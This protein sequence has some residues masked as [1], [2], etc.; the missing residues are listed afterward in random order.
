MGTSLEQLIDALSPDRRAALAEMLRPAVEPV[1]IVGIG[2]RFPG[3]ASSL[4][5][6]WSMLYRQVDA[7][8]E[9]PADRW[10]VNRYYDPDVASPGKM[11]T[12]WGGFLSDIGLFAAP[13][14]GIPAGEALRMDPQQRLLLE[15]TWEALESAGEAPDRL[16]GSRTGVFIGIVPDEYGMQQFAAEGASCFNDPYLSLGAASSMAAG[17]LSYLLDFHGPNLS[18]DTAC[19]SS[20]VAVHL[21]C[22]SLANH[23]C[24][25]ALAGGVNAIVLPEVFVQLCKMS[26]LARD[27]RTKAFAASADGFAAGEGCGVVALKRL[28]DALRHGNSIAAVIRGSAV[29]EDGRSASITAPNQEAQ[30]AVIR[31][32]L[33]SARV[34]PDDV[35]YIEAHGSGTSIG[36][37][38]EVAALASVFG[39]RPPDRRIALG[40]VKTNVGHLAAAA[41]IAGLI[42]ATLALKYGAIP[43]NLHFRNPSPKI[44]WASLPFDVPTETRPWVSTTGRRVAGVSAFGWAGTNAH[45]VL[46]EA[47]ASGESGAARSCTLLVLSAKSEAALEAATERLSRH[48]DEHPDESLADAAFT[49]AEGR[50]QFDYRRALIVRDGETESLPS[51]RAESGRRVAFV[52]AGVGEQAAGVGRTWYADEPVFRAAVDRC[53]A[54]L[55]AQLG[56]DLREVMFGADTGPLTDVRLAQPAAFVLDWALAQVWQAWGVMPAMLLGYSLGEYVAATLAGVWSLEDALR[57]VAQ[58]AAWIGD[59]AEPGG[60]VAI[61]GSVDTVRPLLTADTWVAA[62][63]GPHATLVGGR[64]AALTALTARATAAELATQRVS[65][66]AAFHTPVLGEVQAALTEFVAAVPRQAPRIPL[67]SNVTGTWWTAAQAADAAYWAQHLCAPV[68]FAAGV[69]AML[70]DPT[71]VVL[72]VGPGAGLS[73]FIRQHPAYAR[74]RRVVASLPAPWARVS[75]P[76]QRATVLGTLWADGVPVDWDAY[77][78]GETRRRVVLPTYPFERQRYWAGPRALSAPVATAAMLRSVHRSDLA[79]RFYVPTW[80]ETPSI[81]SAAADRGPVLVITGAS[82]LGAAVAQ[83]LARFGAVVSV[84]N[85]DSFAVVNEGHFTVRGA[86]RDNYVSLFRALA[87]AHCLPDRIVH[88]GSVGIPDFEAAQEAGLY[89]LLALAQALGDHALCAP[90]ELTV[91]TAGLYGVTASDS[92][93]PV[94]APVA[95]ACTVIAQEYPGMCCR[96]IDLSSSSSSATDIGEVERL[97]VELQSAMDERAVAY[98]GERRY[99]RRFAPISLPGPENGISPRLRRNGVYLITGGL[100]AVGLQIAEYLARSVAARLV[101]VGRSAGSPEAQ[102]RVAALRAAGAEVLVLRADVADASQMAAVFGTIDAR[103]GV[104]HGVVHAAGHLDPPGLRHIRDFQMSDCAAHFDAKARGLHVLDRALGERPLDFCV[105]CSSIASVLGGLGS[106]GYT[107]ANA[108]VDAFA[109]LHNQTSA[110]AWTSVNWD[111]WR[112]AGLK[113]DGPAVTVAPYD[114][115]PDEALDAFARVLGGPAQIVNSTGDLDARIRQWVELESV[116]AVGETSVAPPSSHE[117]VERIAAVWRS[118][119]GIADVGLNDNF[120]ELGGNSLIALQ[121]VARLNREFDVHLPTVVVFEAPTIAALAEYLRPRRSETRDRQE[122]LHEGRRIRAR[123]SRSHQ[124]IAIVGMAGRFPGADSVES[125]WDNLRAGRESITRFTDA[126]LREAGVSPRLLADQNYVKARPTL[127][128]VE[129]FDAAL[130][131]YTPRQAE[132][133]DPQ[134]RLFHECAWEALERAGYDTQRYAG[135]VGVYGGANLSSY[136]VRMAESGTLRDT[137]LETLTLDIDKDSLTTSISYKLN[138]RGPSMAVQTFC[139]TSLVAVHMACRSL[140]AGECDMALAGG[141][142][143]WVPTISGYM[144]REGDQFSPDGHCRTFDEQADGTL[145]GDGVALVVL[146]RL[147]DALEDGDMIHAVIRG[148]AVNNDGNLKVSYTGPS[149]VGQSEVVRTA[150]ADAGVT[151]GDVDYVEAHGTATRLGDPIEV[152]ALT[153]AIRTG[154]DKVGYCAIGSVK[155][156]LGHLDRA[157]GVTGLIKTVMA[158]EHEA[159]PPLLHFRRPNPQIDF[160]SS[161]FYVNTA[162]ARWPRAQGRVRRA[163]VNSLGVGGTNAHVVLEEAPPPVPSGPGRPSQLLLLSARTE[164]ALAAQATQLRE[165]LEQHET[166]NLADTAFTLAVGRRVMEHRCF[167]VCRDRAEAVMLLSEASGRH[168]W[169]GSQRSANRRLAFAIGDGAHENQV[170]NELYESE[171]V[172]RAAVNRCSRAVDGTLNATFGANPDGRRESTTTVASLASFARSWALAELWRSWGVRPDVLLGYGLGELVAACIADVMSPEDALRLIARAL[173][174][175]ECALAMPKIPCLSS[176]TG[177]WL[178]ST[179][180]TDP[181][182]WADSMRTSGHNAQAMAELTRERGQVVLDFTPGLLGAGRSGIDATVDDSVPVVRSFDEA[183]SRIELDGLLATLGRLWLLDVPVDWPTFYDGQGRRRVLLPTYPF[184]RQ[185]YWAVPAAPKEVK[186]VLQRR[187]DVSDWFAVPSWRRA[188][189]C[190]TA[191]PAR[192]RWLLFVDSHPLGRDVANALERY[193]QDVICVTAG[194]GFSSLGSDFY[195]VRAD[196]REDYDALLEHLRVRRTLPQRVVHLWMVDDHADQDTPELLQKGFYSLLAFTQAL[197]D[198]ALD[199]CQIDVVSS[200]MQDVVGT[201]RVSPAKAAVLG[202]CRTIPFEYPHFRSRSIDI[203]APFE[204]AALVGELLAGHDDVVALRGPHRWLPVFEPV[205]LPNDGVSVLKAKGTYL[206][207][208]GLGGIA[209]AMAAHLARAVQ[210]RLVLTART[211]LPPRSDWPRLLADGVSVETRRRIQGV[212]R[213]EALGSE[214]LVVQADVA[215]GWAMREVIT[216]AVTRFGT[217]D[218]VL[219]MAGVPGAGLMQLKSPAAA[220][221]VLAPKVQGTLA[222]HEALADRPLDFLV[223]FSS[224]VAAVGGGPGQV[225]YC[226]ANAFLDAFARRHENDHGRTVSIGWGEWEWDAWQEGLR[227]FSDDVRQQLIATRQAFG[228]GFDDGS[229]ALER[230]LASTLSQVLVTTRDIGAMVEDYQLTT[231]ARAPATN[232]GPPC[233]SSRLLHPRPTLSSSFAAAGSELE[234]KI[235][236]LWRITLGIEAV[237]IDDNFFE[238]GGNSLLG[239]SLIDRIRRELGLATLPAHLIFE[240][241]TVS[242]LA[243]HIAQPGSAIGEAVEV[244]ADSARRVEQFDHFATMVRPDE[245]S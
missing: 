66:G 134:Q 18:L 161:P 20:L 74:D 174:T 69:E 63:N 96:T 15:T 187:S 210:A 213:L 230:V 57:V 192:E 60:L 107:A 151:P 178:S 180:A 232:L 206:I 64:T 202:P 102:A 226:A 61:A 236:A 37:P 36:D 155:T 140:R 193:G 33:Q 229:D 191:R 68:Q 223:L 162:L 217:L 29:N 84:A 144:Y 16:A 48:V 167:V 234:R 168:D 65:A 52:L 243:R 160:A 179:Q 117:V 79:E 54:V 95:G 40:A 106:F 2:C 235:V 22:R 153:K 9:V 225:D 216:Q 238:L 70:A 3:G 165:H 39:E 86:S 149:V 197:G 148:T 24:D 245:G 92:I 76:V 182:Y 58:R 209:L 81:R 172:F 19:S 47:P 46:E 195:N 131:G 233:S 13:F 21:A 103:F 28:S 212:Q 43:A 207:T 126:Q 146:K 214:V 139:S 83:R 241:P 170:G 114:M 45:I 228:I 109:H 159:M 34:K 143:V 87:A 73:A 78:A 171:P 101:L 1:A 184:E 116:H 173:P 112:V 137:P 32:A 97:I 121:L 30:A 89:S 240:C 205:S 5:A 90:K 25:L 157:A 105:L 188:P 231:S 166:I 6:Y 100:G 133:M 120:F 93:V 72:E 222:L 23:E 108:Y 211:A 98:R 218:G 158:L 208:G 224:I 49:L 75:E 35:S 7:V 203:E 31:A 227:G 122:T 163:S 201:E 215:E 10:D 17:R 185:R 53:A 27:G 147:D 142:S 41:G 190:V 244:D 14:F 164:S 204:A 113:Q 176:L 55:Q 80:T 125:L 118:L 119:L 11:Y 67:L 124:A 129:S 181:G 154:T 221:R 110:I 136:L 88:L 200:S 71:A 186:P 220:A 85:G 91:V 8:T 82:A 44:P 196:Q 239:V 123:E 99:A 199:G 189:R 115:P 59:V 50:S 194:A 127:S 175:G 156:N 38:I 145:F 152:A 94:Q 111:T 141:V 26:M 150:F 183:V 138:L 51:R 4:K 12:R 169:Q 198:I 237:G 219:H 56:L 130:F 242:A 128:D 62:V 132:L 177:T 77:Y 104:L 135:L 42:K